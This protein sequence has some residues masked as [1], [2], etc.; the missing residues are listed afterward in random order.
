[1]SLPGVTVHKLDAHGR[2][3][4]HY[5]GVLLDATDS[6]RRLLARFERGRVEVGGLV[7]APGDLFLETFYTDRWYN[8][9]DI[10]EAESRQRKGWYCNVT[11][12]AR[13]T[14]GHIHAE[15]L[16]LDLV[17]LPDGTSAILDEDEFEALDLAE[18]EA[19]ACRQAIADLLALARARAGPFGDPPAL[20]PGVPV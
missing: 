7:L 13:F 4:W 12:P 9:F 11:R 2:E 16:A 18:A 14:D 17:V 10:F 6:E 1:M 3:V 19:R 8:V 15:D 20:P 5:P